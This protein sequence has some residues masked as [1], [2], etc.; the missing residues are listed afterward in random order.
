MPGTPVLQDASNSGSDSDNVTNDATPTFD[1]SVSNVVS[2]DVVTLTVTTGTTSR[3]FQSAP[4]DGG[5]TTVAIEASDMGG[6][7]ADG[8]YTASATVTRGGTTTD[9]SGDLSFTIDTDAPTAWVTAIVASGDGSP[10]MEGDT[11]TFTVQFSEPVSAGTTVPA[12]ALNNG[13]TATQ[14]PRRALERV[15]FRSARILRQ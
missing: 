15:R 12:L 11:V 3:T 9:P 2:G 7:L 13:G 6:T 10:V 5:E 8:T 14:R 4:L 1:I